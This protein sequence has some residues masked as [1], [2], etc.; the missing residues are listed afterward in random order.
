MRTVALIQARLG[1]TRFPRKILA[2]LNGKPILQHVMERAKQ[3]PGVDDV[4]VITPW[5]DREAIAAAIRG[6]HLFAVNRLNE[7]DVLERYRRA[8]EQ[9]NADVCLR[10]TADCPVLDP[11]VASQVLDLY[12]ASAACDVASNDTLISGYPDGWDV[13][14]FS[15]AALE[16]A[17]AQA[18]DPSDREH[19]TPWMKRH[20]R[21]VTLYNS[22]P[23]T[24][25][26]LSV[27]EPCDLDRVKQWLLD[28]EG[29][30]GGS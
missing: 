25:P 5:A 14:V 4:M 20:L 16:T 28:R 27:D 12:H 30:L 11:V 7:S 15:R 9:A 3:I 17:A 22:E 24:G 18:T 2:D 29:R 6:I 1:S 19:V 10:L 8:A 26:K 13:E 21:C 23:W